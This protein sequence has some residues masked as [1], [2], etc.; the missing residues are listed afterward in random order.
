MWDRVASGINVLTSPLYNLISSPTWVF[1][2][3]GKLMGLSLPVRVGIGAA[4]LLSLGVGIWTWL[5]FSYK[6]LGDYE[7]QLRETSTWIVAPLLI[8]ATSIAAGWMTYF[9][10]LRLPSWYPEIDAAWNEGMTELKAHGIRLEDCPI[11]VVLGIPD[12]PTADALMHASRLKL[13]VK[14]KGATLQPLVWYAGTDEHGVMGIFLFL[15]TCCQSSVLVSGRGAERVGGVAAPGRAAHTFAENVRDFAV[16]TIQNIQEARRG[17]RRPK[18]EPATDIGGDSQNSLHLNRGLQQARSPRTLDANQTMGTQATSAD[19]VRDLSV[20]KLSQDRAATAKNHLWYVCQLLKGA[21]QPDC[22]LNGLVAAVPYNLLRDGGEF[23]ATVLADVTRSDLRQLTMDV[24]LRAHVIALVTG[25]ETDDDFPVFV[26]RTAEM[27][28]LKGKS[29]QS[30]L[31][32]RFGKGL[33]SW[34]E[35]K[36]ERVEQLAQC[37]C[38]SFESQIYQCFRATLALRKTD[39]GQLYRFLARIRGK[40]APSLQE[41]LVSGFATRGN[42]EDIDRRDL[43]MF[44]GC[45]LVAT[46]PGS[47]DSH[48]D[49]R[50]SAFV[51]GVFDKL[52][53]GMG[54]IEWTD[55]SVFLNH[56]YLRASRFLFFL[57][58]IGWAVIIT[59]LVLFAL[60]N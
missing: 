10:L 60:R 1:T 45:Y 11:F 52:F 8:L 22:P 14:P 5:V 40:L 51:P 23:Q 26:R 17:P 48:D 32:T 42:R 59:V 43:P 9:W 49:E 13:E 20:K 58:T 57:T 54:D 35:P 53:D 12:T 39:N 7:P 55:D 15:C 31:D 16:N 50:L 2:A 41:W 44:A 38:T 46:A 24:G 19:V 21:R 36:L 27:Q 25:L 6:E 37:A 30:Y 47:A 56:R 34:V 18:D 3:P 4:F 28:E 29:P 33:Q